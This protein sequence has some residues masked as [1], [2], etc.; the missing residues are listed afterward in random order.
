MTTRSRSLIVAAVAAAALAACS[1]KNLKKPGAATTTP[2]AQAEAAPSE[3]AVSTAPVSSQAVTSGEPN[4]R[5]GDFAA[6]PDAGP[7]YFDYDR[8]LLSA[9]ARSTLASNAE[10]LKSNP[11]LQVLIAGNCD[12]R[13]TIEYNLALGEKRAKAVREYYILMGVPA[14]RLATISYGKEKPVC[15]EHAESCWSKNRRADTLVRAPAA[16]ASAAQ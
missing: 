7:V 16:Q 5:G 6:V 8:Y 13:G 3:A 11:D 4:I 1:N 15:T 14:T 10:Y 2:Q 9:A 12:E